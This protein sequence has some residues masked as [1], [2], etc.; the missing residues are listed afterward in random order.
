MNKPTQTMTPEQLAEWL[1]CGS[2]AL[3]LLREILRGGSVWPWDDGDQ[4]VIL[5]GQTNETGTI[6][7]SE[8]ARLAHELI[9]ENKH[10]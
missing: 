7:T 4:I 1:H 8:E 2:V 9:E 6:I 5:R 3:D 10:L